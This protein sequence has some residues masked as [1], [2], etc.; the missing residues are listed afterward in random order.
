[1]PD[2]T[3][4][5]RQS[6]HRAEQRHFDTLHRQRLCHQVSHIVEAGERQVGIGTRQ[7]ALHL[8]CH[9][10]YRSGCADDPTW[11]EEDVDQRE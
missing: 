7:S 9:S 2:R 3:E 4:K 8:R 10:F 5:Q 1:M 11:L 6:R